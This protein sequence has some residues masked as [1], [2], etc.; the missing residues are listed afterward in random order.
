MSNKE[1]LEQFISYIMLER[2]YSDNTLDAYRRDIGKFLAF[3]EE[4]GVEKLEAVDTFNISSYI[5]HLSNQGLS[6]RSIARNFSSLHSFYRYLIVENIVKAD[7]LEGMSLPKQKEALPHVLTVDE[8]DRVISVIDLSN[9][10]GLRDRAIL[11]FMY[12]T[13][14]RISE[15]INMIPSNIL[16]DIEV[17]RIFGKGSKERLVPIG[18]TALYWI[19]RYMR[20]SRPYL[21]KKGHSEHLF[22]T[23]RGKGFSRMGMW[24]V[25]RKYIEKAGIKKPVHPHTFR[26]SFATHL[27]EGGADLRAVQEMLGHADI[28]TTQIY[29]NI[30]REFVKK[31]YREFHPRDRMGKN[32]KQ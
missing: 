4:K 29:T 21:G 14:A 30:S 19:K 11:E 23:N 26:H 24:K 5:R 15:V 18:A 2:G 16:W 20:D 12:A 8:I 31:V 1:Y 9:I 28:S 10:L 22:R 6:A 25:V 32:S 7:P 13:G 3:L 17:V 27:I